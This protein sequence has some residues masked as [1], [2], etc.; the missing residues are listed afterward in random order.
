[1]RCIYQIYQ[2]AALAMG[3]AVL[4]GSAFAQ[5]TTLAGVSYLSPL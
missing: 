4:A 2:H 3:A 5:S 1:M